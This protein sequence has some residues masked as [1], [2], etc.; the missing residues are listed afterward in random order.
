[1][2]VLMY[3]F[4]WLFEIVVAP[5]NMTLEKLL[6]GEAKRPVNVV[7]DASKPVNVVGNA[8]KYEIVPQPLEVVRET[9]QWL[10]RKGR[11]YRVRKQDIIKVDDR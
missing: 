3:Y 9:Q 11:S 2:F 10:Y 8:W 7:G 1:M 6:L 4:C 5:D